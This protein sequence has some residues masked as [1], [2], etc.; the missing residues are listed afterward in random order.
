MAT[1]SKTGRRRAKTPT[2]TRTAQKKTKRG[3]KGS[4]GHQEVTTADEKEDWEIEAITKKEVRNGQPGFEVHWRNAWIPGEELDAELKTQFLAARVIGISHVINTDVDGD[5][6][7]VLEQKLENG[8]SYFEVRWRDTWIPEEDMTAPELIEQFQERD[9]RSQ[10]TNQVNSSVLGDDFGSP[11]AATPPRQPDSTAA[12]VVLAPARQLSALTE[13]SPAPVAPVPPAPFAEFDPVVLKEP[14]QASS[15]FQED[16]TLAAVVAPAITGGRSRS[17][18]L[19]LLTPAVLEMPKSPGENFGAS[20]LPTPSPVRD[21]AETAPSVAPSASRDDPISAT[22]VEQFTS[23][24]CPTLPM[25]SMPNSTVDSV[26]TSKTPTPTASPEAPVHKGAEGLAFEV[27]SRSSE[28][29]TTLN[30]HTTTSPAQGYEAAPS[31]L[32]KDPT[33][34]A[35][36]SATSASD[37]DTQ[38]QH[39]SNEP[40]LA[41]NPSI[42][43]GSSHSIY[44]R[45]RS[46]S[47]TSNELEP[48][49]KRTNLSALSD[50]FQFHDKPS[51]EGY[52]QKIETVENVHGQ[53]FVHLIWYTGEHKIVATE[54]AR[55]KF[56]TKLLDFYEENLR[57]KDT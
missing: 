43:P 9:S 41:M 16:P 3:A 29:V 48:P 50:M 56:P 12:I 14:S 18:S 13:H 42:Q 22:V 21:E 57:W 55:S 23:N 46:L 30:A 15:P 37:R 11:P 2:K 28:N 38:S 7:A 35:V 1:P 5:I 54:T 6:E 24:Q 33:P 45:P 27:V 17:A 36:D 25:A 44:K 39:T 53:L 49:A 19:L 47:A 10:A 26:P 32:Q 34:A 20:K 40:A 31:A 8:K 51:W 4:K 52:V